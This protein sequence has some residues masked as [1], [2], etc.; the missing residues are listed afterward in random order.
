MI[1]TVHFKDRKKIEAPIKVKPPIGLTIRELL[2]HESCGGRIKLSLTGDGHVIQ[3]SANKRL[4]LGAR[5]TDES[6]NGEATVMQFAH[7]YPGTSM[8]IE[9]E[10]KADNTVEVNHAPQ[11]A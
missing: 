5:L 7:A 2:I 4:L 1:V 3:A 8:M 10:V 9:G 6:R 11:C